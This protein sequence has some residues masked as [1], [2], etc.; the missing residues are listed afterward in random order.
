M[1]D[2]QRCGNDDSLCTQDIALTY[3]PFNAF[4]TIGVADIPGV[5]VPKPKKSKRAS[6]RGETKRGPLGDDDNFTPIKP[7][8]DNDGSDIGVE[9][10]YI[11]QDTHDLATNVTTDAVVTS[12]TLDELFDYDDNSVQSFED[13][14]LEPTMSTSAPAQRQSEDVDLVHPT[15]KRRK[16]DMG[17]LMVKPIVTKRAGVGKS[18]SQFKAPKLNLRPEIT[19]LPSYD[20]ANGNLPTTGKVLGKGSGKDGRPLWLTSFGCGKTKP[21]LF[22]N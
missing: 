14:E 4:C 20:N 7:S 21:N 16:L 13:N 22:R 19:R 3:I 2:I 10:T 12:V 6:Q 8:I 18:L 9:L 5:A 11:P 17:E 1:N 15:T